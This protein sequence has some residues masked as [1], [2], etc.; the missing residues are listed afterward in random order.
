MRYADA[1][2]YAL[3]FAL[4]VGAALAAPLGRSLAAE[5]P[6]ALAQF[7]DAVAA[8]QDYTV[9]L[10]AHETKGSET[11]DRTMRLS[12]KKPTMAKLEVI[13]GPGKGGVVFWHGGDKVRGHRGGFLSMITLTLDLHDK[14]VTSLRGATIE[15][16]TFPW[17]VEHLKTMKG[18][19]SEQPGPT[20]DGQE[21]EALTLKPADPQADTGLT[22]EVTFISRITHLPVRFQGYEGTTVVRQSDYT[23]LQLNTGLK[24][25]DF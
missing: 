10:T 9:S 2:K 6:T 25:S 11:Y 12:F 5:Q 8:L 14:Q 24:D 21:T 20:I 19:L 1:M 7:S 18:E 3:A 22:S 16:A 4:L 13:A 23:N 15:D 17:Q